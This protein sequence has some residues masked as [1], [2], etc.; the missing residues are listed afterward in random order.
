MQR[1][2]EKLRT[3]R[4]RRDLSLREFAVVLGF[5][6]HAHVARLETGEKMPSAELVLRIARF[7]DVPTDQLMKDELELG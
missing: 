5:N 6:S 4:Q 1:F 7:F 3:L 2:G